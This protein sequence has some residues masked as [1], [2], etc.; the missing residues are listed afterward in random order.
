MR[1]GANENRVEIRVQGMENVKISDMVLHCNPRFNEHE[2]FDLKPSGVGY[3]QQ[4]LLA[5]NKVKA[6]S[7]CSAIQTS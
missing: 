1:D 7:F 3:L 4:K 2:S 6:L 5:Y